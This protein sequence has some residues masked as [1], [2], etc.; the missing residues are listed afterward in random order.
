[1]RNMWPRAVAWSDGVRAVRCLFAFDRP[2]HDP[3]SNLEDDGSLTTLAAGTI[4]GPFRIVRVL[5]RGGMATVTKRATVG[6]NGQS[7]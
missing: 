7:R 5:G 4:V 3:D 2:L 6:S 1:M